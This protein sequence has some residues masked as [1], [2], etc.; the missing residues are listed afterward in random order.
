VQ[1][2][3]VP[4]GFDERLRRLLDRAGLP[5]RAPAM[6]WAAWQSWMRVDKKAD[7]GSIR[8]VLVEGPGRA[9]TRAVDDATVR[10]VIGA[11]A[12]VTA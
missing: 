2:G 10:D 7:A 9:L 12:A 3:L 8:Y 4:Q 5:T 6:P 1:Q 11:H